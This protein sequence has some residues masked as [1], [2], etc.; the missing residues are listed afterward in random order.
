M[1]FKLHFTK[2]EEPEMN[3][4]TDFIFPDENGFKGTVLD[5]YLENGFYRMQYYLFT[6]NQTHLDIESESVPVFWLRIP[7]RICKENKAATI[8]RKKASHFSV[9][10][11]T[12][13]I[14]DEI[15]ELYGLYFNS[16]NFEAAESCSSYLHDEGLQNPF[17]SLMVQ[18]RDELKLIAVGYFDVGTNAMAGIL[19]FYHPEYKKYSL[20]K[21]LMLAKKDFSHANNISYYYLGYLSTQTTKFDY[22]I[23][24]D[25]EAVEVL[26]PL[27]KK[28]ISYTST[29][30]EKLQEYFEKNML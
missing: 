10:F 12:A 4:L 22:K 5:N 20:G 7:V 29:C 3:G 27:E 13:V 14:T 16:I 24:P 2:Y 1:I 8:I 19:N 11:C 30:K 15:N 17:N 25:K 26:L 9:T 23:F 18:V 28:W 6:T 21:L